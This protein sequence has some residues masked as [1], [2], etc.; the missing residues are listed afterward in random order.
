MSQYSVLFTAHSFTRRDH[1]ALILKPKADAPP[2]SACPDS[3]GRTLLT[4][5]LIAAVMLVV[6]V[7]IEAALMA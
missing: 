5:A 2:F 7:A 4:T 1:V 3:L 6:L